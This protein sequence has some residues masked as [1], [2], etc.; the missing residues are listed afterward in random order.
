MPRFVRAESCGF[1]TNHA[2]DAAGGDM[3][4]PYGGCHAGGHSR[5]V[6]TSAE[7]VVDRELQ[8]LG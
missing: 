7:Q 3:I 5:P 4:M 8:H 6:L 1:L 2:R